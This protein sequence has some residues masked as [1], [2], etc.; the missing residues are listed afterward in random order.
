MNGGA[1]SSFSP[2]THRSIIIPAL[3]NHR[4]FAVVQSDDNA[5]GDGIVGSYQL[6]RS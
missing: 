6:G 4:L 5:G 3:I 1:L 2:I